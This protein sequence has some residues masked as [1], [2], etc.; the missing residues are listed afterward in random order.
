MPYELEIFFRLHYGCHALGFFLHCAL[1]LASVSIG[2]ASAGIGSSVN[3]AH[4][5]GWEVETHQCIWFLGR[6][7]GLGAPNQFHYASIM[8]TRPRNFAELF[9]NTHTHTHTHTPARARTHT[10]TH[11]HTRTDTHT[12]TYTHT[13]TC[14]DALEKRAD[15]GVV[16][17]DKATKLQNLVFLTLARTPRN[18]FGD[19]VA[20]DLY[21]FSLH[22]LVFCSCQ[23]PC[24]PPSLSLP[25]SL[26]LSLPISLYISLS[27]S[28]SSLSL[29][30]SLFSQ[31]ML[32]LSKLSRF[33]VS[34]GPF[35]L[36]RPRKQRQLWQ[37]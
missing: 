14:A 15:F 31:E 23:S 22:T 27:L 10:H 34:I 37:L 9:A 20:R 4:L 33:P 21:S 8:S 26:S 32:K 7:S 11:T 24:L 2:L 18:P 29:F 6:I 3:F 12:H 17:K 25:L 36:N 35:R 28:L 1:R 19:C 16:C 5:L 13:H 30:L